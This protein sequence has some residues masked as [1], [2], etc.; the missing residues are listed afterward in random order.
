MHSP[1]FRLQMRFLFCPKLPDVCEQRRLWRDCAYAISRL[2]LSLLVAN[3]ISILCSYAFYGEITNYGNR[4]QAFSR[5]LHINATLH[6]ARQPETSRQRPSKT[7]I[8][9][10]DQQKPKSVKNNFSSHYT[11]SP[12][13]RKKLCL[14]MGM[15][16]ILFYV[17]RSYVRPRVCLSRFCFCFLSRLIIYQTAVITLPGGSY[18]ISTAY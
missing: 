6:E 3:V 13:P 9:T 17:V 12:T 14:C 1:Q 11:R 18:L 4:K 10:T 5:Q 16:D 15:E 2:S 7:E 8:T